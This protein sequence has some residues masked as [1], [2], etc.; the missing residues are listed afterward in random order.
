MAQSYV[1]SLCK[2][3]Y[4]NENMYEAAVEGLSRMQVYYGQEVEIHG[5][6]WNFDIGGPQA[7]ND[8]LILLEKRLK[9]TKLGQELM[10]HYVAATAIYVPIPEE[11]ARP[12][13]L[14][15]LPMTGANLMDTAIVCLIR[16]LLAENEI[17]I[18]RAANAAQ[19]VLPYV[20][21][22]DGFY[23]DGSFIQHHHIPYAGGYGPDL[24]RSFE[25]LVYLLDNTGYTVR[26]AKDFEHVF[27]WIQ[28]AYLPLF[29]DGQIMDMVRGRKSSRWDDN[30]HRSGRRVLSTL[31][32]LA[33]YAPLD[34]RRKIRREIK[35]ILERDDVCRDVLWKDMSPYNA[36]MIKNLMD[37]DEIG[38]SQRVGHKTYGN[39]DR[40][41]HHTETYSVGISMYSSRIGRF[42]CGNG[43]NKKGHHTCAGMVYLYT[44]DAFQ[45]G[46]GFWPT[47]DPMRL[48]GITTDHLYPTIQY[49]FDNRN[50]RDWVGGSQVNGLY[51]SVGMDVELVQSYYPEKSLVTA[52]PSDLTGKKSWFLFKDQIICLGTGICCSTSDHV[53]T[54][55]ENRKIDGENQLFSED[56][57][58]ELTDNIPV[59]VQKEWFVLEGNQVGD[60]RSQSIGYYIPEKQEVSVL[61]E[62]RTGSWYE[63]NENGP[64]DPITNTYISIAFEHGKHPES[65][66]YTYILLPGKNEA[67]M[68]DYA[69]RFNIKILSN[70]EK[71]QAVFDECSGLCGMNF[72]NAGEIK[73][74]EAQ[75][76][77]SVTM[78]ITQE[79]KMTIGISD[80]THKQKQIVLLLDGILEADGKSE[81]DI[82]VAVENGKTKIIVDTSKKDG[83]SHEVGFIIKQGR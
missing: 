69:K 79:G 66:S 62:T 49:W 58:I 65:A 77:C 8:T 26:N 67:E 83:V 1:I 15:P 57:A 7:L 23:E 6:W 55:V 56:G 76:P 29:K 70:T 68:E 43:E 22:G 4:Q 59:I 17:D 36:A 47:V 13:G 35:G 42:T 45:F 44:D 51:G 30:A 12:D 27:S 38:N 5:N 2:T 20:T 18:K 61:K 11:A 3:T 10:S 64:L 54:I 75:N 34:I 41:V 60:H 80:P 28:D 50:T 37:G 82:A 46:N 14:P 19:A 48:P 74:V 72:W 24:I 9:E 53:E 73:G 78:Q 21:V 16:G 71:L 39:M 31:L 52:Q 25:N 81:S 63:I 33:E 40:V 32:L